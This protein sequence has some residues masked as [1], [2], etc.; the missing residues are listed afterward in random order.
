[1]SG[2]IGTSLTLSP[3]HDVSTDT[4]GRNHAPPASL[5][6]WLAEHGMEKYSSALE[7]NGFDSL[8][9]MVSGSLCVHV[10]GECLGGWGS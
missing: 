4:T 9:F 6:S 2:T 7:S 3:L 1:M 5:Q 8:L 10:C